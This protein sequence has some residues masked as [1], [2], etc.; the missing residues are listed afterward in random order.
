MTD[1]GIR[2][3]LPATPKVAHAPA[4]TRLQ[5]VVNAA[6][7]YQSGG[8]A[9]ALLLLCIVLTIATP[10][11]LTSSNLSVVLLQVAPVGLLAVPGAMLLLSGYIDLSIGAVAWLSAAAFGVLCID[12]GVNPFIAA[13]LAV[14]I[15]SAWG[16][17]NGY[18]TAYLGASPIVVTLAGFAAARGIGDALTDKA[19]R[20]GFGA[21]FAHLGNT[22]IA[23][24]PV[25]AWIFMIVFAGGAYLWYSTPVGRHLTAIGADSNAARAVG[26]ATRKLPFWAYV[27]TGCMAALAGLIVVS[28]LNAAS[29]SIGTG[30]EIQ[31]LTAILLGGVA[32][33]GGRG[34]LWGVLF[35][36]L[37]V[38]LLT[39]GLVLLNVGPFYVNVAVGAVLFVV[40][41]LDVAYQRL[42]KV[43]MVAATVPPTTGS[44]IANREETGP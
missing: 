39:N 35:G 18:L 33:Q 38:G 5:K 34:S 28:Q 31:V 26:I 17:L 12:H 4:H 14:G 41:L 10:Q 9:M 23:G 19:S 32:F 25:P 16:A 37:F 36:V 29:V 40:A 11:F 22:T 27:A 2:P 42:E 8:L 43:P 15:G 13:L 6:A 7:S 44:A 1:T 20:S 3:H 21:G 30:L 24:L